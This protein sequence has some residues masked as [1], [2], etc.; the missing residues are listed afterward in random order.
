[1]VNATTWGE[2]VLGTN[3]SVKN[4]DMTRFP[5]SIF[6]VSGSNDEQ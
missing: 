1:M 5:H 4:V 6:N 3:P 2:N